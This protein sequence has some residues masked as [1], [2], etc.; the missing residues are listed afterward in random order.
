[1]SDIPV[2]G[3]QSGVVGDGVTTSSG[4]PYTLQTATFDEP[5][6]VPEPSVFFL[7]ALAISL[8]V[9]RRRRAS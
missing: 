8:L 5:M 7:N 9:F 6:L 2:L 3:T 1:M 4:G